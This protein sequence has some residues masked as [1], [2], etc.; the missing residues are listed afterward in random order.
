MKLIIDVS[1]D[2]YKT[3]KNNYEN[4]LTYRPYEIIANGI[5]LDNIKAEIDKL[6][7]DF[8]DFYDHTESIHDMIDKA[9]NKHIEKG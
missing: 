9:W 2:E 3:I 8:G 1:E 4:G 5:P 6:D 7:F